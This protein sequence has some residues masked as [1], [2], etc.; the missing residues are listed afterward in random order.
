MA[1]VVEMCCENGAARIALDLAERWI[2]VEGHEKVPVGTWVDILRVSAEAHFVSTRAFLCVS[3]DDA[4]SKAFN[5][6]ARHRNSMGTAQGE[7]SIRPR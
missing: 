7:H 2:S 6:D 1:Q 4:D 5:V 3:R